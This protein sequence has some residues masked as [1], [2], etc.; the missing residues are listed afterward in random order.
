MTMKIGISIVPALVLLSSALVQASQSGL[1]APPGIDVRLTDE[2]PAFA[3][4]NGM[5]LYSFSREPDERHPLEDCTNEIR[6]E[7][8]RTESDNFSNESENLGADFRDQGA[9]QPNAPDLRP[10]APAIAGIPRCKTCR[11]VDDRPA[12]RR[13]KAVGL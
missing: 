5:T 3:G 13:H 9:G 4:P 12:H 7:I 1:A 6:A 11:K 2:G 8:Y 10:E